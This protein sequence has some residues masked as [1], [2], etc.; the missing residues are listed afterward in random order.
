MGRIGLIDR[1]DDD[2]AFADAHEGWLFDGPDSRLADYARYRLPDKLLAQ[3][4][5]A[6]FQTSEQRA[7]LLAD[8]R[9]D[10]ADFIK[11]RNEE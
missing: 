8:S 11:T 7:E 1:I 5:R 3:M 4:A 10:F 6:V 9:E 2:R